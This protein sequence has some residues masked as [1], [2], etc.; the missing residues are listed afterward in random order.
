MGQAKSPPLLAKFGTKDSCDIHL[1][2]DFL[3]A[4]CYFEFSQETGELMLG[5]KSVSH[6][7]Q[8]IEVILDGKKVKE[9]PILCCPG[10]PRECAVLLAGASDRALGNHHRQYKFCVDDAKFLLCPGPEQ[11]QREREDRAR[12]ARQ[13]IPTEMN[14][15]H[16]GDIST[17]V[18]QGPGLMT[19]AVADL[20]GMKLRTSTSIAQATQS[21]NN[22]GLVRHTNVKGLGK[23]SQGRVSQVLDLT[24]GSHLACKSIVNKV[25]QSDKN[26]NET[27]EAFEMEILITRSLVHVSL[28]RSLLPC[29]YSLTRR[30]PHIVEIVQVPG[31]H[32][33]LMPM[34]DGS[35]G[36]LIK[37]ERVRKLQDPGNDV[38][39]AKFKT[40]TARM[41]VQILDALHHLH[42]QDIPII[43]RDVK[44][45][46]ILVRDAKFV[47]SDFGL[48]IR[49]DQKEVKMQGTKRYMAPEVLSENR[50]TTKTDI[51]SMGITLLKCLEDVPETEGADLEACHRNNKASLAKRVEPLT[52]M[53]ADSAEQR[54]SAREV[55]DI[56]SEAGGINS[57]NESLSIIDEF[58]FEESFQVQASTEINDPA[59]AGV[60]VNSAEIDGDNEALTEETAA[61]PLEGSPEQVEAASL[62]QEATESNPPQVTLA[63]PKPQKRKAPDESPTAPSIAREGDKE[64]KR[65]RKRSS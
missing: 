14:E 63:L 21:S 35:L 42:S 49:D 9:K 12:F 24:N 51:Y 33:Y 55:L 7:T 47:L 40:S 4:Q 38:A 41:T 26:F 1:R 3:G 29:L 44:P 25:V 58:F 5:D 30:Q 6:S 15:N 8:L 20:Q 16:T 27:V 18:H 62:P 17:P 36:D 32:E 10:I 39:F 23:G 34:Y 19:K 11:T 52:A 57:G 48:A 28:T 50:I 54:P 13:E 59:A 56:I 31:P 53:L 61:Q 60:E 22:Q 43:H 46:N 2:G 64:P 37:N 65:V 45:S